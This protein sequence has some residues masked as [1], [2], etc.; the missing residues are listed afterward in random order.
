VNILFW[1]LRI[2]SSDIWFY[3]R[4]LFLETCGI[5][6]IL[7]ISLFIPLD[8]P[9]PKTSYRLHEISHGVLILFPEEGNFT[10]IYPFFLILSFL[11]L[12]SIFQINIQQVFKSSTAAQTILCPEE[13][14]LECQITLALVCARTIAPE[15]YYSC[16]F[17][18]RPNC[19]SIWKMNMFC[20]ARSIIMQ[21]ILTL[22]IVV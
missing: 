13:N 10:L 22:R 3:H 19:F 2:S 12:F 9:T 4:E 11:P 20:Y 21:I 14:M 5:L 1:L 6:L 15:F 16:A 8:Y 17:S 7:T 18:A